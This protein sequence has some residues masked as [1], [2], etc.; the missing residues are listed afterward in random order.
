MIEF[1]LC[2]IVGL[3]AFIGYQLYKQ[4]RFTDIDRFLEKEAPH[5]FH[6]KTKELRDYY[7]SGAYGSHSS[8]YQNVRNRAKE[9]DDDTISNVFK[10]YD[11]ECREILRILEEDREATQFEIQYILWDYWIRRTNLSAYKEDAEWYGDPDRHE[12]HVDTSLDLLNY[13]LDFPT[14]PS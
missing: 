6:K 8:L 9:T 12:A 13:T 11:M 14:K 4:N 10:Y 5:L 7:S 1:L 2:I 3:L